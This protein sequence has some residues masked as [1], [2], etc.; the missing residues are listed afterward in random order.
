[1]KIFAKKKCNDCG[2][3]RSLLDRLTAIDRELCDSCHFKLVK[4]LREKRQHREV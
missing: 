3:K 1:M 4:T 2:V